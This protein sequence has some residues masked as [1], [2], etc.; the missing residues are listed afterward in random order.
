VLL[1]QSGGP[2]IIDQP[3]DDVDSKIVSE[4]VRLIWK[5]K[6]ERQLIFASHNANF[7]VNGDAEL[8]ICCDYVRSGD[9][10]GGKVKNVGAIDTREVRADITAVTEGGEKAF[11]LR[12]EKYGF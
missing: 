5:A 9:Q 7:V 2:L 4:I 11:K 1:N 6:T 8:V 12:K 10:T 3:E